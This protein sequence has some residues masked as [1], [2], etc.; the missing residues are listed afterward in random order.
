[1]LATSEPS[2]TSALANLPV[3]LDDED[4]DDEASH[5]DEGSSLMY[6]A[7]EGGD[8]GE[9]FGDCLGA[10]I[11]G[12]GSSDLECF[13][14][15]RQRVVEDMLRLADAL[16]PALSL[17]RDRAMSIITTA[18]EA[19]DIAYGVADAVAWAREAGWSGIPPE[20]LDTDA[21]DFALVGFDLD[22]LVQ[23]RLSMIAAGRLSPARVHDYV[24]PANPDFGRILAVAGGFPLLTD[25]E[26]RANGA[27]TWPGLSRLTRAAAAP[28]GKM[29]HDSMHAKGLAIYL[30]A[31]VVRQYVHDAAISAAGWATAAGK[32]K[33]RAITNC[34]FAGRGHTPLNSPF[35]KTAS[36]DMWGT[37]R[38]P[39]IGD[40]A[41][42]I[43]TFL[44][45]S[46]CEWE[47][48]RLWKMD[49]A[50]A[51]TLLSWD[52]KAVRHMA[53]EAEDDVVTF[54]LCGI[55]GWTGMP[56]VFNVITRTIVWE[57]SSRIQGRILMY[58]D[59]IF[60]V[61]HVSHLETD[62]EQC[63]NFCRDL[64]GPGAIALDKTESGRR[65][66][67]IGYTLDLDTRLVAIAERNAQKALYGY[68][69]VDVTQ[70]VSVKCLQRLG[71]WG[72]RY[73]KICRYMRPFCR[74]IYAAYAGRSNLA[75]TVRLGSEA[76]LVVRLFR[77]LF[78]LGQ[79]E[80]VAFSRRLQSFARAEY[81][82]LAVFD[83][84]LTGIGIIWYRV[85]VDHSVSP[86]GCFTGDIRSLGFGVDSGYQNTAEFIAAALCVRGVVV[87]GLQK[88]PLALQGDSISALSWAQ[89]DRVRSAT[90]S[91]AGVF[92]VFQ[93]I[94]WG[95]GISAIFHASH[96]DNWKA[97][98]FSREGDREGLC[99]LD[100]TTD[101]MKVPLIDLRMEPVI[102]VCKPDSYLDSDESFLAFLARVREAVQLE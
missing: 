16:F 43:L 62:M 41:R 53:V 60:G 75:S 40:H 97:D 22:A 96:D 94:A 12:A 81:T 72:S 10:V 85:G 30:R 84:S 27:D 73:G 9:G 95:I 86:I 52:P 1:V 2:G 28:I 46:Q 80:E 8:I 11:P 88:E 99:E 44:V 45:E 17:P 25:P 7:S 70:P 71:S 49:L 36:D 68:M 19:G 55:F 69:L 47:D 78:L 24:N 58:V 67:S 102:K 48:L 82:I 4:S 92:Y 42:L 87:M 79:C 20:S 18:F 31:P 3:L 89:K 37:I 100:P 32:R 50:G 98:H 15:Y 101:W 57:V 33:G 29:F 66:V 74:Y 26:F 93:N 64:L 59:D 39:T 38:L 63:S 76:R 34:S 14:Q 21:A 90:A 65:L 54:F 56:A 91:A 35:V 61:C 5:A 51:F 83:A 6:D 77:A 13:A 23:Q